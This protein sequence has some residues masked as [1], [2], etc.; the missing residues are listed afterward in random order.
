M[1]AFDIDVLAGQSYALLPVS[2]GDVKDFATAL[3]DAFR[4]Q[5]GGAL[6]GLVRVIPLSRINA[7]LVVSSQPQYIEQARRVFALID[8]ARRQT[9]RSWHVYYL[10]NSHSEDVA[11][12]LQQAFTPGNVTAQPTARKFATGQSARA[13]GS[14]RRH[15]RQQRR[16]GGLGSGR[17]SLA[18][19]LSAGS[20]WGGGGLAVAAA[21]RRRRLASRRGLPLSSQ[22]AGAAPPGQQ[23]PAAGANPLLGGL[24]PGG[25]DQAADALRVIPDDQNNSVLVYGTDRELGTMEAMLRKID[26]LPLQ[27]RID[28]VIAEVTLNDNLKFGT[29]FFFKSGGINGILNSAPLATAPATPGGGQPQ[30]H[31]SRLLPW[32][33]RHWWRTFRDSG[34]AGGNDR[35]CACP[36]RN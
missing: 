8:R 17:R 20:A 6:A 22:T 25:A 24:E 16:G 36:H 27:V 11:F 33:K 10:Q 12:V 23:P 7:V 26:I 15:D 18:S 14:V 9:L 4:G 3:Q 2:S 29:Q 32:R 5:N 28:A 35:T 21:R 13:K 31:F 30:P 1:K 34:T 19:G